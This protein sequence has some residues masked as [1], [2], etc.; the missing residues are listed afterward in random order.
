MA[1]EKTTLA[2]IMR[3]ADK[4]LDLAKNRG[5]NLVVPAQVDANIAA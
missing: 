2:D 1:H 5:R 4:A 3:A